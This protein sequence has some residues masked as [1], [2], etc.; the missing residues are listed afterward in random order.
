[1]QY[2]YVAADNSQIVP[3]PAHPAQSEI[4]PTNSAVTNAPVTVATVASVTQSV[5]VPGVPPAKL[6]IGSDQNVYALQGTTYPATSMVPA[7]VDGVNVNRTI[8]VAGKIYYVAADNSEVIFKSYAATGETANLAVGNG[9]TTPLSESYPL[10][11]AT[12]HLA[13]DGNLYAVQTNANGQPITDGN[14]NYQIANTYTPTPI[15]PVVLA[16]GVLVNRTIQ[17]GTQYFYVA[18]DN[19]QI[20]PEPVHPGQSEI[21]STAV[22][23]T[24]LTL[25]Q[26]YTVPGVPGQ[27]HYASDNNFYSLQL[28]ANGNPVL[29]A[30]NQYQVNATYTTTVLSPPVTVAGVVCDRTMTVGSQVYYVGEND[31]TTGAPSALVPADLLSQTLPTTAGSGTIATTTTFTP[32]YPVPGIPLGIYSSPDGK[33]YSLKVDSNG[34]PIKDTNGNDLIGNTYP[35][36]TIP[37]TTVNGIS[38]NGTITVAV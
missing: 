9:L 3:E 24:N 36:T 35:V 20:L 11:T 15:N 18:A 5:T 12:L 22:T 7:T 34:N 19:S 10:P 17:I 14:G 6:Y 1:S 2:F 38:V 37:T 28:D 21:S 32:V 33:F 30:Q 26:A 4:F 27:L 29:N 23:T 13:A 31:P 8:N 16:N 25:K